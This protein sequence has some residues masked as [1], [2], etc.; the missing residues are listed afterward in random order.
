M[1][2]QSPKITILITDDHPI[3]RAGIRA[4]LAQAK[5]MEVVGEAKDGFEAQQLV[6]KL[7]PQILL[8]DLKMPGPRPAEIEKW[9]R[10]NYPET[11]TLVLTA[12]DRDSYLAAMMD[13]G[14]V[15]YLSK[16][17]SEDRLIGAIRRAVRGEILFNSTQF[18]R[19]KRWKEDIGEKLNQL[20]AREREI[21]ELLG[22]G[23]DNK[24]IGETLEISVKTA[25]YHVTRIMAKLQVQS[26]Q[27]AAL[28]ASQNLSDNLE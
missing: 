19:V 4:I 9:V 21:L 26:R 28:W 2:H 23:L 20:T 5:D 10:L 18:A 24:A 27:E 1:K 16:E 14:A 6:A 17:E 11:I 8:L 12:H 7:R 13:A 3:A 15:G 25:A 22:K